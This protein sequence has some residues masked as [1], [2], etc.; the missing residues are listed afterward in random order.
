[1]VR[2]LRKTEIQSMCKIQSF[3]KMNLIVSVITSVI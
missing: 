1:M 2:I 3:V